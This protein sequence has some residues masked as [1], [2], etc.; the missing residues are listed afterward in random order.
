MT[1]KL[2]HS[3]DTTAVPFEVPPECGGWVRCRACG[4]DSSSL[5]YEDVRGEYGPGYVARVLELAGGSA[6]QAEQLRSNLDWFDH[7]HRLAERTFLDV[8]CCDGEGMTGMRALGWIAYG[9]DVFASPDRSPKVTVA[10]HFV[11]W[12][13]PERFA[14]V[15]CREVWE[16]VPAPDLFLHELHGV[17][18]PGGLVQLQTPKPIDRYHPHLY[19]RTHLHLASPRQ[20]RSMLGGAMLEIV[21]AREWET[22]QAYLCRARS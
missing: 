12:L 4:S 22:G 6:G 20:I 8:G 17:T 14:A 19:Q 15:L 5:D 11:R 1:C 10:P 16:H 21:D 3:P 2:C 13:F 7:H 18:C 9:F